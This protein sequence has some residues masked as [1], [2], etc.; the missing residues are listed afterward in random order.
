MPNKRARFIV[1]CQLVWNWKHMTDKDGCPSAS[2]VLRTALNAASDA[3]VAENSSCDAPALALDELHQRE[4][5]WLGRGSF[6]TVRAIEGCPR[7]TAKE[8]R[9][10]GQSEK[11][12]Q[13]TEFEPATASG[14]SHPGV[15]RYHQALR[16]AR[17]TFVVMDRCDG[18]LEQMVTERAR[19]NSPIPASTVLS[20][21]EQIAAAL[22]YLHDPI[23][24][25]ANGRP[26]PGVVHRN[27]EPANVLISGDGGHVVLAD[28][29]LCKDGL[30]DGSTFVRTEAYITPETHLRGE[31]SSASDIWALGAIAYE[32]STLKR[33]DFLR[34]QHPRDVFVDGWRPDLTAVEDDPVRSLL[35][36][37]F[38]LDL[39]QRPT[40]KELTGLLRATSA[41]TERSARMGSDKGH[42][43]L[44]CTPYSTS[45][46]DNPSENR[47]ISTTGDTKGQAFQEPTPS[48]LAFTGSLSWTSLI[49]TAL[50]TRNCA[51]R[52]LTSKLV[53]Q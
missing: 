4:G 2:R 41:S 22:A 18:C 50:T 33:P 48:N 1:F 3:V 28:P 5:E 11:V 45:P 38:I 21:M 31:T 13:I 17:S 8:I 52:P 16:D 44:G 42:E 12:T 51:I 53:K 19:A 36:K 10:E 37:V 30:H 24:V 47:P 34:G 6:G 23:E 29:G 20:I 35:K 7:L 14:F 9:T 15:A 27:L 39:S 32:L 49:G 26:L 40:A 25:D 43:S 46:K